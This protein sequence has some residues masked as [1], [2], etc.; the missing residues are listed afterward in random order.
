MTVQEIPKAVG[1]YIVG[2]PTCSYKGDKYYDSL[3][4]TSHYQVHSPL[5]SDSAVKL[6]N[7]L[8]NSTYPY[9]L[10]MALKGSPIDIVLVTDTYKSYEKKG[11]PTREVVRVDMETFTQGGY[12][13]EKGLYVQM[14]LKTEMTVIASDFEKKGPSVLVRD[15]PIKYSDS[16]K[17]DARLPQ[18]ST[19]NV[20]KTMTVESFGLIFTPSITGEELIIPLYYPITLDGEGD[21]VG[22][23][24]LSRN[25][26]SGRVNPYKK[27]VIKYL[28]AV[29]QNLKKYGLH[30]AKSTLQRE[31]YVN[32][33][34]VVDKRNIEVVNLAEELEQTDDE[35]DLDY[36]YS[37]VGFGHD[38]SIISTRRECLVQPNNRGTGDFNSIK[39]YKGYSPFIV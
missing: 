14:D 4:F 39:T 18:I 34:I 38:G 12:Y 3:E 15:V 22:R 35:F 28:E 21:T 17:W 30:N 19:F 9:L 6:V 27:K 31:M 2:S 16:R 20:D 24:L 8:I 10:K 1:D 26:T 5:D 29:I 13:I 23:Y 11:K 7:Y 32:G 36:L 25:Q 33:K 37:Q